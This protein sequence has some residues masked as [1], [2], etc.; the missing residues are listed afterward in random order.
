M[1]YGVA[2]YSGGGARYFRS[3]IAAW[4]KA[5]SQDPANA[6]AH[7]Y[8]AKAGVALGK[9]REPR[10]EKLAWTVTR[11]RPCW[12]WRTSRRPRTR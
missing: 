3:A 12:P 8:Y 6:A 9:L 2:Q 4:S 5:S 1:N 11:P 10:A 7:R